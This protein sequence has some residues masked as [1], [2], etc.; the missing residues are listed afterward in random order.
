MSAAAPSLHVLHVIFSLD[1][2]RG[3]PVVALKNLTLAQRRRGMRVRI[4]TPWRRGEGPTVTEL[5]R[6]RGIDVLTIGPCVGR[7]MWHPSTRRIMHA[8]VAAADIVHIHG[9]WEDT[10]HHAATTSRRLRRPYIVRPC[11]ML[12]PWILSRNYW[13]K[14]LFLAARIKNNLN[15]A[16]AIH[17]TSELEHQ[18]VR[19]L[20]L[21]APALIEGNG[22][23]LDLFRNLPARGAFRS[24]LPFGDGRFIVFLGRVASKKGLDLILQAM[25]RPVCNGINLAVVGPDEQPYRSRLDAVIRQLGLAERVF[26]AGMLREREIV[27]ALVDADLSVLPSRQENFATT[28]LE[29]LA[30]GTPVIVSDRVDIH[31]DIEREQ[32]GAVVPLDVDRLAAAI[33]DWMMDA[34]RRRAAGRRARAYALRHDWNQIAERWAGHYERLLAKPVPRRAA[35]ES[36]RDSGQTA[37]R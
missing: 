11:G 14:R 12:D 29:S 17:F 15:H 1:E 9:I 10:L 26:F 23:D 13:L 7:L 37:A 20:H 22:I 6:A 30:A 36:V 3:G 33:A 8:A 27:E 32:T 16:T 31:P 5:L 2:T 28:V 21:R 18:G 4:V 24:K 19:P 25:A 34:E 35:S